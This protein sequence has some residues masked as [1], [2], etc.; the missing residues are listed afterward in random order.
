MI[1][2][3]LPKSLAENPRLDAWIG[4]EEKGFV[5]LA[6]GKVEIG[7][8]IL[9]ALVQIAAEE[10]DVAPERI[11][12]VSG[13]TRASP[14]EGFTSGSNSTDV[15]GGAVRL[16][17]AEVRALFI[18]EASRQLDCAPT[19]LDILDGR[20]VRGRIDTVL[21]YWSLSERVD[22]A[23]QARASAPV[24]PPKRYRIV[25]RNMPRPDL[26]AKITG[27]AF[28]HDMAPAGLLHARVLHRPWRGARLTAL[29]E[30]AVRRA[31]R[32]PVNIIRDGDLVAFT[33]ESETAVMRALESARAVAVWREGNPPPDDVD[34]AEWLKSQP[35]KD[36]V[37]ETGTRRSAQRVQVVEASY[38][39]SFLAHGAI[40]PS[41]A[42][43]KFEDGDLT[44][45][46]HS[47][48][49]FALREC[50]ALTLKLNVSRVAVMHRQGSGCYGHN[51]ADDAAFDAAF[52]AIRTPGRTVRVQ[53]AREDEMAIAPFGG[54][55]AVTLRAELG[56]DLRP[57]DW[58]I[59]IWSPVQA[60]RPGMNGAA[61]LLGA[62]ALADPLPAPASI[63]DAPDEIGGGATRNAH[64]YYDFRRQRVTHHLLADFPV[65]ASSVR[66]LGA[67]INVFAIESFMDELADRAGEDPV[68]WRLALTS[69]LRARAVIE[70]AA[71]MAGWPGQ[72]KTGEGRA[73]GFGFARYKN[74]AAYMAAV[75]EVEVEETVRV[76]R[77][78]SAVDAGLVVNPDGAASQIEGGIVQT[79]S[80]LLKEEIRFRNGRVAAP[81][82][83]GY[84]I[85]RFSEVPEI[86]IRFVEAP[87]EP[88]L[89]LGEAAHG[90]TAA[91]VGNAVARALGHRIRDLPMTRERVMNALL[92]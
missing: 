6:T 63:E 13:D 41:C 4:F 50:L 71:E 7:Q 87:N 58:S 86:E 20:I 65:R 19:E 17:C 47:Q 72:M 54:A 80:W 12:I 15:S 2:N 56:D 79:V 85:L 78:W 38:S 70:K 53:W 83:E 84:P 74:R 22:L 5:R 36:R 60:C 9:T 33:A 37:V 67:Y 59:E 88:A 40:A 76:V 82:W 66:S 48:G 27:G 1:A 77:V 25:G 16:V 45:W 52:V 75:A 61:N 26:L 23:R 28:I 43:A 68:A 14:A 34:R 29:D 69:D 32:A 30:A 57:A 92:A 8:G 3:A 89:G 35:S 49:V 44:V 81:G 42:L 64:A 18:A 90:P 21:D 62:E 55:T 24:K 46:T 91:A 73:L 10:L 51:S 11:K 39:R 31:A